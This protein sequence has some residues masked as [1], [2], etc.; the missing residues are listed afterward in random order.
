[1]GRWP[2]FPPS[3]HVADEKANAVST[4]LRS[5]RE[6][7]QQEIAEYP[8]D[9]LSERDSKCGHA[10][11]LRKTH[12][13]TSHRWAKWEPTEPADLLQHAEAEENLMKW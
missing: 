7:L 4:V 8:Y 1:V 3:V 5:D 13:T 10:V 11:F 9:C 12:S 2:S 6:L